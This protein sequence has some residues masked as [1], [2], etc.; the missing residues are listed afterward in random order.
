[1]QSTNLSNKIEGIRAQFPIFKN[2][3]FLNSSSQG[4]LS[5]VVEAS[6]LTHICS[7]HEQGSPWDQWV[8]EYENA[9][10]T[11]ARLIGAEPEEVAVVPSA[12][13]G[14]NSVASALH[15][16][17]RRKV[18]MG[19]FE[20]PTR[21]QIWLARRPRGAEVEFLRHPKISTIPHPVHAQNR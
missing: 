10:T 3:I 6:L 8:E 19:E 20:F 12:S 21:G 17:K 13:A 14:I 2:K 1:M 5:V 16:G 7:W 18:V 15:F 9:R 11:F 4:A